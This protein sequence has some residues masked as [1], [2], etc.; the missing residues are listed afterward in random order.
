MNWINTSLGGIIILA[1]IAILFLVEI[2][3]YKLYSLKN[4]YT[5]EELN[6][7]HQKPKVQEFLKP[8]KRLSLILILILPILFITVLTSYFL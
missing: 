2:C 4:P 8:R 6:K 7:F 5:N 1:V 3:R